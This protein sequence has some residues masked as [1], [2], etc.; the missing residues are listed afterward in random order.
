M[1]AG[2]FIMADM[3]DDMSGKGWKDMAE[4]MMG[5]DKDDMKYDTDDSQDDAMKKH[6][7]MMPEM[8]GCEKYV[9]ETT[10]VDHS[11]MD[12]SDP[13]SMSMADM[14]KMLEG[15]SGDAL[16]KAFLEGM[17][18]HHQGAIDMA[19]YL[20]KSTRPELQELGRNIIAAQQAEIEQMQKWLIEWNLAG[21]GVLEIW[22]E[23]LT[24]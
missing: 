24:E 18:P 19:K 23:D 7:E 4:T 14:G 9:G 17:I 5:Q 3:N 16:D 11:M 20:E 6:C 12:M 2:I 8:Q 21:T 10:E 15:K 1:I 13:M 22:S